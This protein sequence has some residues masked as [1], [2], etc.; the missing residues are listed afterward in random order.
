[1]QP[2]REVIDIRPD[3]GIETER[4]E[5]WLRER[6]PEVDGAF[7]LAQFGGGHANLTYLIRFGENEYVLRRPPL[8]PVAPGA[9]DMG[10][11]HAVLKGLWQAFP[12]AP[13]SYVYCNDQEI[14]G[15][16]FHV[17]ERRHGLAIRTEL[18]DGYDWNAEL[19]RRVGEMAVDVLA[20]LHTADPAIAGLDGLGRPDGFLERQMSGWS[21]RWEAAADEN[22]STT[23]RDI[24]GWLEKKRPES[25]H[26]SLL[27]NDFKLDNMLVAADDPARAVAVLDWDMCTRGDPLAD[28]GYMLAFWGEAGDDPAWIKGASMPTWNDGFPTRDQVIERYAQATG[29]DCAHADWYHLFGVFKIA[30]ILQ[31]IYIRYLRGQTQDDRFAVFGERIDGL[32][33]KAQTLAKL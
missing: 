4:L 6:L 21:R 5:P 25:N 30:V 19:N 17:M 26:V 11:E 10:R 14:I 23:M 20:S 13:Q 7:S 3:E 12:L 28:L 18:P 33:D 16:D 29:F 22:S 31:Q 27:H 8:G 15:A 9:H 1:M 24:V 2:D 32:I